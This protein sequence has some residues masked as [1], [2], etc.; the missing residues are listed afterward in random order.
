MQHIL[1]KYKID[2]NNAI[3]VG[4]SENDLC[5]VRN[6]GIGVSFCSA[7]ELLNFVADKKIVRSSFSEL[8][9]FA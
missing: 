7:N 3:A 5:M 9:E 8:L 1:D 4:D 6:V 2:V